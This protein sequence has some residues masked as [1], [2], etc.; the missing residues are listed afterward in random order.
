MGGFYTLP[1]LL[2]WRFRKIIG[3]IGLEV[4]PWPADTGP[5]GGEVHEDPTI[6]PLLSHCCIMNPLKILITDTWNA[7]LFIEESL[8]AKL[9]TIWTDGKAQPGRS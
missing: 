2:L 3:L 6:I 4:S 8:E 9:P 5:T 7:S 1:Q